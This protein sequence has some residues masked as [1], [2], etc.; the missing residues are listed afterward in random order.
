M[1]TELYEIDLDEIKKNIERHS[2][3]KK[4]DLN[5]AAPSQ[6][7]IN[8]TERSPSAV[9]LRQDSYSLIDLDGVVLQNDFAF[10]DEMG[11]VTLLGDK[12]N[13]KWHSLFDEL[14]NHKIYNSIYVAQLISSRRWNLLLKDGLIIKLPEENIKSALNSM[15]LLLESYKIPD[16]FSILDL[17]LAPKKIYGSFD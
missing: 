5:I 12:A 16:K 9:W 15:Q 11:Y 17:R 3:I 4:A 13:E 8:I 7:I 6:L 10:N 2:Y 1:P 14:K